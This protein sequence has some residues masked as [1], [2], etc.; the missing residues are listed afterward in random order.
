MIIF[1]ISLG[2]AVDGTIHVLA[3][4]REE[5]RERGLRAHPALIRAARGTGRAIVISCATLMAGFAVLLFSSFVPV[6]R[7]GELIA[8]TVGATLFAT[9]IVQPALLQIAGVSRRRQQAEKKK[10]AA[11]SA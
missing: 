2:L 3:R 10:P 11:E 9:L 7:F 4:F 1:S 8:V 6:R 5:T